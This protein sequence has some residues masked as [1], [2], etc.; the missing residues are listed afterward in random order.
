MLVLSNHNQSNHLNKKCPALS[1]G[2]EKKQPHRCLLVEDNPL[3][4]QVF[5]HQLAEILDVEVDVASNG[6]AA[7]KLFSN[8]YDLV[9]MDIDLPGIS[10]IEATQQIRSHY[11]ESTTLIVAHTSHDSAQMKR[12]CLQAGMNAFISKGGSLDALSA[13]LRRLLAE[14]EVH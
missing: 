10:G 9:L 1:D 12:D 4:Q 5:A 14:E 13:C 11:P 3:L 8:D 2:A 6:E 7:I